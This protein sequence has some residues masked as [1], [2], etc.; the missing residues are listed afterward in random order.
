MINLIRLMSLVL[1]EF[2]V[3]FKVL[4]VFILVRNIRCFLCINVCFLCIVCVCSFNVY[5]VL[6]FIVN[7]DFFYIVKFYNFFVRK[8]IYKG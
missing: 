1:D 2:Y 6:I 8:F 5:V 7:N 4:N 3:G